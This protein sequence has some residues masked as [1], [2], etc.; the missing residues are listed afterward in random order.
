MKIRSLIK[1]A[2]II[3]VA[4]LCTGFGVYSFFRLNAVERQKDFNL[5]SLV[6]QNAIAV[7]ETDH[8]AELIQ[9][10][11]HLKCSQDNHFLYVSDIFVALKS[12]LHT[13]LDETPHGL[14]RQ[15]SKMIISF[16]EPDNP[17]NQVLYCSLGS[18]DYELVENFIKKYCSNTFPVKIFDYKGKEIKIYSMSDGRFLASYLTS[19]FLVVSFQKRLVEQVIDA[20]YAK[21]SLID[22]SSFRNIIHK[23][24]VANAEALI[25]V[26]MNAVNM[27]KKTGSLCLQSYLGSW[28]EFELKLNENA[29]YCSGISY[30]AD[31]AMTFSKAVRNQ[32]PVEGFFGEKLP[33][34]T[35][36]YDCWAV[37]DMDTMLE[38]TAKQAY[39]KANYSDDVKTKDREW[40]RFLK[41]Y[42]GKQ[43]VSCLF[44]SKDTL[45]A[46]PCAILSIPMKNAKQAEIYLRILL[47]STSSN[48]HLPASQHLVKSDS[49]FKK[50]GCHLYSLIGN[51]LLTQLT[52]IT[53]QATSY[54]CFYHGDLLIALDVDSLMEYVEAM[55]ENN[56]L[57][58]TPS[59]EEG[60][61]SLSPLYNFM[62]MA[63]MKKMSYQPE[64]YARLIPNFFFR[65]SSFFRHFILCI[66]FTCNNGVVYPNIVLLY[67]KE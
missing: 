35:F 8:M 13:L 65:Q 38:F 66:Q 24:K 19:R 55:E 14:S 25:Y 26:R 63:D 44:Q 21:R 43:I 15:M 1:I 42:G 50:T 49:F 64:A 20:Q 62:I 58:G 18:G 16:H 17:L 28:T 39:V 12:Y 56:I 32:E 48:G 4:L 53:Q 52:G 36:F 59:Y 54:A 7:V 67:N 47:N 33:A 3:S 11:K 29:I 40:I 2:V 9:R 34:S 46:D 23:G 30:D 10:I 31:T 37:S 41:S 27:G 6:P 60:I 22:L 57:K 61:G 45:K 51:A 5:Y